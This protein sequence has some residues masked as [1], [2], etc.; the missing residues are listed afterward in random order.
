MSRVEPFLRFRSRSRAVTHHG[1]DL[2]S[3]LAVVHYLLT[4][5]HCDTTAGRPTL[6]RVQCRFETLLDNRHE[7]SKPQRDDCDDPPSLDCAERLRPSIARIRQFFP[8]IAHSICTSRH[9]TFSLAI[10]FAI[11][12]V[13]A[14]N[15]DEQAQH[16][17]R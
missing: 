5:I 1:L 2:R 16:R 3:T 17:T 14:S 6:Q 15:R 11:A 13:Y 10:A 9:S 4:L 12:L 8:C 7:S